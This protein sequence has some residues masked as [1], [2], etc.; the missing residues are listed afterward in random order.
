MAFKAWT[1]LRDIARARPDEIATREIRGYRV[2]CPYLK[3]QICTVTKVVTFCISQ[4]R[5]MWCSNTPPFTQE[6]QSECKAKTR[7]RL[8]LPPSLP[9]SLCYLFFRPPAPLLLV[10][11]LLDPVHS[12]SGT[13]SAKI[14][15]LSVGTREGGRP[16]YPSSL[17]PNR[18]LELITKEG[19][20]TEKG[21]PCAFSLSLSLFFSSSSSSS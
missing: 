21:S 11:L 6:N 17:S 12:Q 8:S 19:L 4:S 13:Y 9:L 15:P 7:E 16:I 14:K 3:G 10:P 2:E 1:R 20:R 5:N 18:R